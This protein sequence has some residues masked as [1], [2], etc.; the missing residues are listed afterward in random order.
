MN[1]DRFRKA[2]IIVNRQYPSFHSKY[3]ESYCES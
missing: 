2:I 1:S 3:S